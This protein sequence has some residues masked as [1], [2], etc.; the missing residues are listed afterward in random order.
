MQAVMS[1]ADA[2]SYWLS[3]LAD[4]NVL[5]SFHMYEPYEATSAPNM[6]RKNP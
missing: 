1:A 5:Y 2:F 4:N 6:K 3:A